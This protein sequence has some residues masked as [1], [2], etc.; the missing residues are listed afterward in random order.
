[1]DW[2]LYDN[3][4]RHERVKH[5]LDFNSNFK[6]ILDLGVSLLMF[7]KMYLVDRNQLYQELWLI[8]TN[9]TRNFG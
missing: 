3:G 1:M 6:H 2:F 7:L 4:P 8:E 5:I 9:Y